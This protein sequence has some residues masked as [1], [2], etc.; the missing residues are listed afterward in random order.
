M[1]LLKLY[2]LFLNTILF[3]DRVLNVF[4]SPSMYIPMNFEVIEPTS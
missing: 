4:L 3:L 2:L 1:V